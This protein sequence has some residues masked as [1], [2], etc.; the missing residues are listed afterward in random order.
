MIAT[1]IAEVQ[2]WGVDMTGTATAE[3]AEVGATVALQVVGGAMEAEATG[4]EAAIA[5]VVHLLAPGIGLGGTDMAIAAEVAVDMEVVLQAVASGAAA[6][7]RRPGGAA[8]PSPARAPL[9][10]ASP[11]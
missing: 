5:T 10:P 8:P 9:R 2:T 4:A 6:N 11:A 1:M 7:A 3:V